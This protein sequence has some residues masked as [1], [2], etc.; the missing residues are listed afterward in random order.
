VA[1]SRPDRDADQIQA[2][3]GATR[4]RLVGAVEALVDRLHPLRIKQREVAGARRLAH[5]ELETLKSLVF[6]AR[7]DLRTDR[8]KAV[9]GALVGTVTLLLVLRRLV[10]RRRYR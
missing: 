4:D 3:V 10:Q 7:G 9:G 8:L 5:D 1:T 2:D 6:T